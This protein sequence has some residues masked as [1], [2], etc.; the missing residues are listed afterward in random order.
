[1]IAIIFILEIIG[2]LAFS[3]SGTITGIKKG[4]DIF[5]VSF[6]AVTTSVG[7]GIIRDVLIGNVPPAIFTN[8]IYVV[9]AFT[10]SIVVFIFIYFTKTMIHFTNLKIDM[11]IDIFDAIGLGIFTVNGMNVLLFSNQNYNAFLVVFVGLCTGIGGGMIRDVLV[12]DIPFVLHRRIYAVAAMIGGITYYV[13]YTF[14]DFNYLVSMTV[15]VFTVFF[16]RVLAVKCNWH[17]PKIK[18]K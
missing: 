10:I 5:G 16:I 8:Y 14:S 13:L 11:I 17:L 6:L 1:M 4:A 7:G 2:T 15:G 12:N 3:I 18:L 9:V